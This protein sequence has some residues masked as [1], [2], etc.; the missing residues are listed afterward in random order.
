MK[1]GR[2]QF[3][4][5]ST[6]GGLRAPDGQPVALGYHTGHWE[7]GLMVQ[8]AAEEFRK[9]KAIPFAGYCSDP[10]DGRTQGTHGNVRQPALSQRCRDCFP[11]ARTVASATGGG[12][13]NRHLRQRVARD[14]DGCGWFAR[15][16]VCDRSRRRY[17]AG[18]LTERTPV[19]SKPWGHVSHTGKSRF[20]RRQTLVAAPALR[21]VAAASFLARRQ[22][23]KSS[24]KR[25]DFHCPTRRWRHRDSPFGWTWRD[26]QRMHCIS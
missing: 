16:A 6:Q 18:R 3:L 13:G 15:P 21:P 14:D 24:G 4:I 10:C 8:A 17:P 5:L 11:A 23:H 9:L 26:A 1:S 12:P 2:T 22:R 19:P 7:I 20:R 25:L